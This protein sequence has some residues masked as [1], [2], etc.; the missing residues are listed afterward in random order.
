MKQLFLVIILFLI[1]E[2]FFAQEIVP[3]NDSVENHPANGYK[4]W[5]AGGV[6]A[7]GMTGSL[8]AYHQY[9]NYRYEKGFRTVNDARAWLQMDKGAHT[10]MAYTASRLSFGLWQWAGLTDKQAVWAGSGASMAYLTVKEY[11][12]GHHAHWGWSWTD[13]AADVTGTA[14]FA[15]QQ[16]A[17]KEQRI[18]LKVSAHRK[19]YEPSLKERTDILFGTGRLQ[20][21]IKDYNGQTFWVS[22]NIRSLLQL[23]D[24]PAWLNIS[25]GLGAENMFGGF[26]NIGYDQN[27]N[28]IF[29]RTDLKR[30]RQWYLAPD[31]DL[32]RIKT[33][34]K[35][36]HTVFNVFNTIKFPAP[37]LELS[38]GKL[39]AHWIGF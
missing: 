4:K 26:E 31:V 8:V 21:W 14:L 6:L 27:G 33:N 1:P 23:P 3:L 22:A 20:R 19:M 17:W 25:V 18:L 32:S 15:A 10:Y 2:L 39:K 5:V 34:S 30:H 38:N 13:M 24:F 37:A 35:V 11:F 36:L 12:D 16:L 9:S 7:T 28:I 29:N